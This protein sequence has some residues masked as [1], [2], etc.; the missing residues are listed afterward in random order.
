MTEFNP[1]ALLCQ[2]VRQ[3]LS[4][5][6]DDRRTLH[7]LGWAEYQRMESDERDVHEVAAHFIMFFGVE[8]D[9]GLRMVP[10]VFIACVAFLRRAGCSSDFDSTMRGLAALI[11][12]GE[13]SQGAIAEH[14][15]ACAPVVRGRTHTF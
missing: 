14:L 11:C 3:R 2:I 5:D 10:A 8:E 1:K 12:N 4:G 15:R 13:A 6:R 7:E 9:G